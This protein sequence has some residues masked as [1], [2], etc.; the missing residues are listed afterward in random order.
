[1]LQEI[2]DRI[3]L[4]NDRI[5]A[6]CDRAGRNPDE[7]R[8]VAVSKT[9]PMD[10]ILT[11]LEAGLTLLGENY[12][13][14][15]QTKIEAMGSRAEWHFIGRLQTKK[16]KYAVRLFQLIHSVDNLKLALELDK[17]AGMAGLSQAVL[18]QVNVSGEESKRRSRHC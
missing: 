16:A 8:V 11:G 5:A 9:V 10:T 18:V 2:K 4:V 12:L 3:K 15:A 6:A 7:V 17:R 1:M 14:E 13:Q